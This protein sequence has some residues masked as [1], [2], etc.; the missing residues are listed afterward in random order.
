MDV[1]YS[2][3]ARRMATDFVSTEEIIAR[4]R[5]VGA[6]FVCG[7]KSNRCGCIGMYLYKD[8]NGAYRLKRDCRST[9]PYAIITNILLE[10]E[11][12][13]LKLNGGKTN[14]IKINVED[15]VDIDIAI[16]GGADIDDDEKRILSAYITALEYA[17]DLGGIEE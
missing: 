9:L 2:E 16:R 12:E 15:I 3:F 14:E 4:R 10:G 7:T 11:I 8:S 5:R 17:S 6:C 13:I 1:T